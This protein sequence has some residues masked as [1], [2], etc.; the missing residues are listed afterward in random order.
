[1]TAIMVARSVVAADI[2]W[3]AIGKLVIIVCL[4]SITLSGALTHQFCYPA[5][6][7]AS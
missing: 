5:Q 4:A 7:V 2:M 3:E 1:M 6:T